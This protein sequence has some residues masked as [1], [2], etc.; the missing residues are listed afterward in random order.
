MTVTT[1]AG[2]GETVRHVGERVE[3]RLRVVLGDDHDRY[4]PLATAA[5]DVVEAT[6]TAA[7][8]GGKRL[9]PALAF[10]GFVGAGGA[11]DDPRVI[12]L[13]VALE[14]LHTACLVHD[15]VMDDSPTRRG[16]PTTHVRFE[17][18]HRRSGYAGEPRRFGEGV[19]VAVGD[20]AFFSS[21]GLLVGAPAAAQRE[22]FQMAKDVCVGQYLDLLAAAAPADGA[23]DPEVIAGYKTAR[24]TV[25]GPLRLGAALAGRLADL[26]DALTGYG[27]PVGLAYQLRDDLIG[28]LGDPAV[29]G[30]PAGDD[31]R[32]GKRTLLL[33]LARRHLPPDDPAARALLDRVD[34][35]RLREAEVPAVRRL[36]RDLA[37]HDHVAGACAALA[38]E[39][40]EAIA[41]ADLGPA[42]RRHLIQFAGHVADVS[43]I[44]ALPGRPAGTE[45]AP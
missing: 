44:D 14:L 34:T 39:A 27:R 12:D 40:V 37:I 21:M 42:V 10:L 33:T 24:Y 26:G 22:F 17:D 19:A 23:P 9:R 32:Q 2:V 13:G 3:E 36:L 45:G 43:A 25:E 29:T 15:D 18:A 38:A 30:K 20:F 16:L 5:P 7:L 11:A 8:S 35:G 28:A 6:R 41:K 4:A 31:L 1:L